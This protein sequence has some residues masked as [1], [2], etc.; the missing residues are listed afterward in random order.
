MSAKRKYVLSIDLGT[1]GPKVAL[2]GSDG[3][4]MAT[5]YQSVDTI[6]LPDEGAE[7]DGEAVWAA[8]KSVCRQVLAESGKPAADVIGLICSSQY[9]S[10]IPVDETGRP[11]M[12]MVLWMDQRGAPSRLA[13][14]HPAAKRFPGPLRM[15]TWLRLH[16]LPPMDSGMDSLA[17]MRWIKYARPEIYQRTRWFL[18]PMDY[19]TMRFT[20]QATANQCSAFML[21]TIDNRRLNVT[22]HCDRLVGYSE[23]DRE[24]L[25]DLVPIDAVVGTVLPEVAEEIGLRPDT[26]VITGFNDTQSGGMASHAFQGH[27]AGLSIGTTSVMLAHMKTK[28]TSVKY[29][30][31]SNP[32][33][34]P[35]TYFVMAENGL[36]GKA[37]EHLLTQVIYADD[38][39]GDHRTGDKFAAL[40][41]AVSAVEPGSDGVLFLPWLAGSM[42]PKM[43]AAMRGGFINMSLGTTRRHLARAALEGIAMNIRWMQDAVERFTKRPISHIVF[44]GGGAMSDEWSQIL[45][46][47]L[48]RPIH[49]LADCRYANCLGGALLAFERLGLLSLG[50]FEALARVDRV[51]DPQ[52]QYRQRY[53][54]LFQQFRAAFHRNRPI[55]RA[56]DRWGSSHA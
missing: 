11:T 48:D 55:S 31:L 15:L 39:F 25:P 21:L 51:F 29:G 28:R 3:E 40:G 24:K 47:I 1:S 45:A 8:V 20:G 27:H 6:F 17:H 53:D 36:G 34:V 54:A 2:V 38:D 43:D 32:S 13:E 18:E 4:I 50:D 5:G 46:D 33:P 12:N 37:L 42:A 56:L 35:G 49:R 23:I 44:Y 19:V 41:R 30:L 16:G 14:H 7:Q 52:A 26:R 22:E 10:I 9:S